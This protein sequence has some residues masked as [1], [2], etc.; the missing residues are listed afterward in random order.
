MLDDFYR[1]TI[2]ENLVLLRFATLPSVPFGDGLQ[3]GTFGGCEAAD[4]PIVI[5]QVLNP[6]PSDTDGSHFLILLM[7]D[8]TK[9]MPLGF[10]PFLVRYQ[11]FNYI[12]FQITSFI[13]PPTWSMSRSSK[14]RSSGCC[15]CA[16]FVQ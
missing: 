7:K 5:Y 2:A 11:G 13:Y 16:M 10:M 12:F 14:P 1:P 15:I 6:M 4:A 3:T 9:A 8:C